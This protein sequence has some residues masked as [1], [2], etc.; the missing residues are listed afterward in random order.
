M[1]QDV[2][3]MKGQWIGRYTGSHEGGIIVNIDDLQNFYQGTV[4][5][6]EDDVNLPSIALFFRTK[7]KA[8][9]FT[10]SESELAIM[11]IDRR[12]RTT[13]RWENVK[14]FYPK[15]E[16]LAK[17][18]EVKG[19]FDNTSLKLF[20]STDNGL[21][22]S[23][24]LEKSKANQ[25]S[26]LASINDIKN[27]KKFKEFVAELS[28]RQ[29]LFRGQNKPW[30]LRTSFHR[31]G[32]AD[33]NRFVNEDIQGLLKH[34]SARTRHVFNLD[35]PN[36]NGAFFNLVQHHGYP[37][38]LMDWT[39]SPFVAAFFA[40]RGININHIE[41]DEDSSN[42]VRIYMFDQAAWKSDW[43]QILMLSTNALHLSIGEFLAIENE[44]MIP[45]QA[46]S[47]ITNIDDIETYVINK[48]PDKKEYLRAI[49]LPIHERPQVYRELSLMGITAGSLFP[50]LDGACEELKE[51]NFEI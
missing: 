49:D 7:D 33:I 46:V 4:Y 31:A 48:H 9:S 26:E 50:G 34:I 30:R 25:P 27:W 23:C 20:W 1:S 14:E 43:E 32:R 13:N 24:V 36:E 37:T 2:N 22:G 16:S 29:F 12:T 18:A 28:P 39:Y 17:K 38:P 11:P 51:R 35:L 15:V 45:Q 5:L 6:N 19:D 21:N 42:C 41:N 3:E 10:I 44:R 40:Y 47:T 8:R